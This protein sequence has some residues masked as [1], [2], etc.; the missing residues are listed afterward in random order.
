MDPTPEE[1]AA[2]SPV[3]LH[4]R[5]L[6]EL[7]REA[8]IVRPALEGHGDYVLGLLV[9]PVAPPGGGEVVYRQLG[10]VLT[11]DKLVT[12]RKTPAGGEPFDIGRVE[13]VCEM[14]ANVAPGMIAYH[15]VDEVAEGYLDLLDALDDEVDDLDD[16]VEEW[17]NEQVQRRI[18]DLR[19][20]LIAIRR[21]LGPTRDAVRGVVDGRTDLEG[22]PLFRREVFPREVEL[23]FAQAY[24][25]L[26]RA[27]DGADYAR[28]AITSVRDYHQ[29]R[30]AREQNDVTK[31]L[32]VVASLLLVPTF[33]VGVYGQNFEHFP[34]LGWDDGYAFSWALI[35]GSTLVQLAL[36][37]WRRW[38]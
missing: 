14:R 10:F 29:A 9:A 21:T 2:V 3:E 23:H 6:E 38:I 31:K 15:L 17:P 33:I 30:I 8:G 11:H 19:Q 25:K 26:L 1:L 28:E 16:H 20:A 36:F 37:R 35:V 13:R 34:E 7:T 22:R 4:P 12:V 5:A 27:A 18:S 32:A 24:E